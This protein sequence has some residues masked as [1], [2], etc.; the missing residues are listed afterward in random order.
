MTT[1]TNVKQVK[2][3][4]MTQNQYNSATKNANELYMVTDAQINYNDLSNQPTIPTVNNATLTITQG[5]TTKGTFTANANS[6]VT[7]A[8]DSGGGSVNVDNKSITTNSSDE[9][10]TVGVIN[11]RDSSTA[12]KTW[13][14]TEAQYDA[15]TTKDAN[16]LYIIL[17]S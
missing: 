14:G 7:I 6:D 17:E 1:T 5:G 3:N 11:S 9:I 16:T 8:L 10:Q 12:I 13:A 2:L 15:I 4:V